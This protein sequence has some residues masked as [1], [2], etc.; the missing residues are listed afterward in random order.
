MAAAAELDRLCHDLKSDASMTT[1]AAAAE[2]ALGYASAVGR[3]KSPETRVAATSHRAKS[4][5]NG[6]RR[7]DR[8]HQLFRSRSSSIGFAI[9]GVDTVLATFRTHVE[10]VVAASLA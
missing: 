6:R 8:G 4:Q 7:R 1:T 10:A 2:I 5:L 3:P 9:V